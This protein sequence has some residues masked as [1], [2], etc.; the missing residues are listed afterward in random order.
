MGDS[1][2]VRMSDLLQRLCPI[3]DLVSQTRLKK[4]PR[5]C[6]SPRVVAFGFTFE[7]LVFLDFEF[8]IDDIV[9]IGFRSGRLSAVLGAC[10]SRLLGGCFVDGLAEFE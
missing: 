4:G 2:V 5:H 7:S 1:E 10:C 8:S 9:I 3:K 6:R